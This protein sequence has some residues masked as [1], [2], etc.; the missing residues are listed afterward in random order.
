MQRLRDEAHRF[1]ITSIG[2][3]EPKDYQNHCLTKSMA[4]ELLEKEHY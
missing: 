2:Q 4:S 1:A 3:K